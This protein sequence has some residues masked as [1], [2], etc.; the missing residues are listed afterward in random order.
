MDQSLVSFVPRNKHTSTHAILTCPLSELLVQILQLLLLL[1]KD[2]RR[3]LMHFSNLKTIFAIEVVRWESF[4][5]FAP[6]S[7]VESI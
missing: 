5:H 1:C 7:V 2:C 3:L 4:S 6:K